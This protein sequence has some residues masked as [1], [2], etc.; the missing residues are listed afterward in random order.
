[1]KL[2][3][4]LPPHGYPSTQAHSNLL[5]AHNPMLQFSKAKAT[6]TGLVLLPYEGT[7]S[8]GKV[9]KLPLSNCDPVHIAAF[10]HNCTLI[11]NKATKQ[12]ACKGRHSLISPTT[13]K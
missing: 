13:T 1:M 11:L 9:D 8:G 5:M 3:L 6:S 7:D 2:F 12:L 4:S 10:L